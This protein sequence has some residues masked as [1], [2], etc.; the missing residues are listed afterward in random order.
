MKF[1]QNSGFHFNKV[2]LKNEN[3]QKNQ[4]TFVRF[5]KEEITRAN[6]KK[7]Y[8]LINLMTCKYSEDEIY[9]YIHIK[10]I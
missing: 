10:K 7:K 5:F 4:E 9:H 8:I 6:C 2:S 3:K 1:K